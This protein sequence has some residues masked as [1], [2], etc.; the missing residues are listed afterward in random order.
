MTALSNFAE[1]LVSKWLFNAAAATRPTAW[2]VALHTGDP[3]ET[4]AS[5]EITGAG[6]YARQGSIAFTANGDGTVDNDA[7]IT[8]GPCTGSDWGTISHISIWDAVTGGNC[9]IKG[10]L[11]ASKTVAV[12]DSLQFAA[13]ALVPQLT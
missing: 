9:L 7:A 4:G 6:G 10:A 1:D 13:A 11:T 12:G 5:N 8:F 3:G 2:Y